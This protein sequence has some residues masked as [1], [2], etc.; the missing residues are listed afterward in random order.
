MDVFV[1]AV[2]VSVTPEMQNGEGLISRNALIAACASETLALQSW[3][4]R[5]DAAG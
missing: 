1:R 4:D 2:V 3:V 5:A